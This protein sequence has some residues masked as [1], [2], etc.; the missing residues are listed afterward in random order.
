[1]VLSL[2]TFDGKRYTETDF[3]YSTVV[4]KPGF[5]DSPGAPQTRL[6]L[7]NTGRKIKSDVLKRPPANFFSLLLRATAYGVNWHR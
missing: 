5:I 7:F 1:M 6:C 3:H 4:T 2:E